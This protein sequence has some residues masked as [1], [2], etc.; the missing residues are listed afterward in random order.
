LERP[1]YRLLELK[2]LHDSGTGV[3]IMQDGRS[4]AEFFT[5]FDTLY[6][7]LADGMAS[8]REA[9]LLFAW[10][11]AGSPLGDFFGAKAEGLGSGALFLDGDD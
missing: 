2:S 1:Y 9:L 10:A 8:I 3:G 7:S 4:T 5:Q 6:G 11:S